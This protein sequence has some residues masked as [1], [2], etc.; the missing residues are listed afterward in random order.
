MKQTRKIFEDKKI[1]NLTSIKGGDDGPIDKR[2]VKK[3]NK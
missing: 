3:Q 1:K 2:K